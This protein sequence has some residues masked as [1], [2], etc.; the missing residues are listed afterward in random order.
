MPVTKDQAQA[1]ASLAV[2][3][4]PNGARRWDAAGV[5]ANIAKVQD[6]DLANVVMA[7]MRAATDKDAATPGVIP[8]AGPHWNERLTDTSTKVERGPWCGWCGQT[9][10]A[11]IHT[12]DHDFTER[13]PT[14]T[15]E[16]REKYLAQY[17]D[18]AA[19]NPG[20]AAVAKA[21]DDGPCSSTCVRGAGHT[22]DHLPPVITD[23]PEESAA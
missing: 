5:V 15:A 14:V 23:Q 20:P 6:R 2:A 17:R 13:K 22:G 8:T 7:V 4:R 3:A 9:Q 16:T 21:E 18:R 11:P 1:L 10:G 12:K 19:E